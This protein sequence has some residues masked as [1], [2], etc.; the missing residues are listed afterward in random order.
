MPVHLGNL[1]Q[2]C[3]QIT[4]NTGRHAQSITIIIQDAKN[5]SCHKE[6]RASH[7]RDGDKR[8]R[9]RH[10]VHETAPE[11]VRERAVNA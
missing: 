10:E 6:R 8:R 3:H 11:V 9:S 1:T 2:K 4:G 5:D 7:I